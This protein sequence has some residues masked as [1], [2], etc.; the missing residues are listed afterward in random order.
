M[1][2]GLT[3]CPQHRDG[4]NSTMPP[5]IS[6]P[7]LILPFVILPWTLLLPQVGLI[8]IAPSRSSLDTRP[9]GRK[10]SLLRLRG[11]WNSGIIRSCLAMELKFAR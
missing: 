5:A 11:V 1:P 9:V 7:T 2:T 8:M 10:F 4:G 3:R 6:L